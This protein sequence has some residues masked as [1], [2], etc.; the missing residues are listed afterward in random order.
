MVEGLHMLRL[1]PVHQSSAAPHFY[2][3]IYI[4]G[5]GAQ[6]RNIRFFH[7]QCFVMYVWCVGSCY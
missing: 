3:Q 2:R 6:A 7:S 1:H 5:G 4:N